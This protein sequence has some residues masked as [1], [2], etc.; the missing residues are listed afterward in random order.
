MDNKVIF[1]KSSKNADIK[2]KKLQ[3]RLMAE[4]S[5]NLHPQTAKENNA[6]VQKIL[7]IL[8]N[9]GFNIR[10]NFGGHTVFTSVYSGYTLE[11]L[12]PAQFDLEALFVRL[13]EVI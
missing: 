5:N 9:S 12:T 3:D 4:I 8:Q 7:E 2:I 6:T 13:S 10:A 11:N 1:K